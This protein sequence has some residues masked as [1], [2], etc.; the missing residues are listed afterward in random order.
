MKEAH[1]SKLDLAAVDTW[2]LGEFLAVLRQVAQDAGAAERA[3]ETAAEN[4][5]AVAGDPFE[6]DR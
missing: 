4:G 5:P 6:G 1:M 3:P 2:D